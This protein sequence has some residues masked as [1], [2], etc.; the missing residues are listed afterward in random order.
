MG[1]ITI[2]NIDDNV[3]SAIKRKA[4]EHGV[5]MEE[6]IR[7]LLALTYSEDR[8]RRQREW[9]ERQLERLKRGEL[10]KAE[11]GS[12]EEVRA[13]RRERTE[14]LDRVIRGSNEPRR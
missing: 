9:A 12:V 1:A 8:Q 6:E 4:A 11:T 2:R 3:V 13:M 10:P 7:T 14:Q 5:S